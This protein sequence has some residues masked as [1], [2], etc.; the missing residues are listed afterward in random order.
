[1]RAILAAPLLMALAAWAGEPGPNR[2]VGFPPGIG[3]A[4]EGKVVSAVN[5]EE[6][7]YAE[8]TSRHSTT[9]KWRLA[10]RIDRPSAYA[11]LCGQFEVSTEGPVSYADWNGKTV[12]VTIPKRDSTTSEFVIRP[13]EI[14]LKEVPNKFP[15]P[16]P[17]SVAPQAGAVRR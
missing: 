11:G 14:S 12:F 15:D 3:I 16:T 2:P 1:M 4:A 5:A 10:V 13:S 8:S 7:I 6:H 17:T 9:F